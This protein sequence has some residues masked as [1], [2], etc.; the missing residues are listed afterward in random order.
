MLWPSRI[1]DEH[2]HVFRWVLTDFI[3]Y[4]NV[5]Y[6]RWWTIYLNKFIKLHALSRERA[7]GSRFVVKCSSHQSNLLYP[8]QKYEWL[9]CIGTKGG[10]II[11]ITIKYWLY[12]LCTCTRFKWWNTVVVRS[13]HAQNSKPELCC[14]DSAWGIVLHTDATQ[15]DKCCDPLEHL[16]TLHT[17]E[18]FKHGAYGYIAT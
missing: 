10:G 11:G 2:L 6:L 16:I 18:E 1:W 3:Q 17:T 8:D 15:T 12:S 5:K 9:G 13:K 14:D 4:N 7:W